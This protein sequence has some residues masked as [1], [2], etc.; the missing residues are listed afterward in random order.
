MV[1]VIKIKDPLNY[2]KFINQCAFVVILNKK[3]VQ[4]LCNEIGGN[5]EFFL[6]L[7]Y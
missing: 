3:L 4:E 5:K 1:N 2:L 6:F 7:K